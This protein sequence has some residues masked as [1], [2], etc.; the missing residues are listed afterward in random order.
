METKTEVTGALAPAEVNAN[1]R[2]TVPDAP[3]TP[4]QLWRPLEWSAER[5]D[6]ARKTVAP[7]CSDAEFSF[8]LEWCRQTGLNPFLKQAY[9][10]ERWD[11]ESNIKRWEPMVAEAGFAA[12]AD[13]LP[14]FRGMQ[15]GVVYAGDDFAVDE[16]TGTIA[17]KWS[18]EARIKA[19]NRVLGAWAHAQR[20]GRVIEVTYLTIESRIQRK[21]DGSATKFWATD[22]AGQ[23]RKCARADQYRRAYPNIF[24]GWYDVAEVHD[25]EP[26]DVT[27]KSDEPKAPTDAGSQSRSAALLEHMKAKTAKTPPAVV[28]STAKTASETKPSGPPPIDQLRFGPSKGKPIATA[29]REELDAALSLAE[30]QLAKANG[31]EHWVTSVREGIDAI[32]AELKRRDD[33]LTGA[34][35]EP[36][37]EG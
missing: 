8:F 33:E 30:D 25:G 18:A 36:G 16:T 34:M 24:A 17:H 35:G 1:G 28:T 37:S 21:R 10:V 2:I 3:T 7:K 29:S 6:L 14:D 4:A 31:T 22:P 5:I 13:A 23:L 11:S 32:A 26:I 12:R 19:G 9:I 27:P 15:S 20:A